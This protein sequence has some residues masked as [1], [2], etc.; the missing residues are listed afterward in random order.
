MPYKFNPLFNPSATFYAPAALE[1][2]KA[3]PTGI[4][5]YAR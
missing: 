1:V 4:D 2:K 5:L 3:N